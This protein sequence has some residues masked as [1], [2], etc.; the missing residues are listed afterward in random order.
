MIEMAYIFLQTLPTDLAMNTV[1]GWGVVVV[2][3]LYLVYSLIDK[4]MSKKKTANTFNN[5]LTRLEEQSEINT[6]V[7][8]HLKTISKQYSEELNEE[9]FKIF[10]HKFLSSAKFK[11]KETASAIIKENHVNDNKQKIIKK[12]RGFV[13]TLF[14]S[15]SIELKNFKFSNVMLSEYMNEAWINE[16][17]DGIIVAIY[18]NNNEYDRI[19]ACNY[20]IQQVFTD[21]LN[22]FL[23]KIK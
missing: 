8:K 3:A 13:Q 22:H 17:T 5:I 2:V 14:T 1:T 7:V 19:K 4:W 20:F 15:D 18:D 21:I 11:V 16:I 6:E 9:Q 12:I 23:N 10:I